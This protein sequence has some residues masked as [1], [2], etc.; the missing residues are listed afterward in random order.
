MNKVEELSDKEN[1]LLEKVVEKE[2]I[3]FEEL[4]N[5]EVGMI[6]RLKSR[7][8]VQVLKKKIALSPSGFRSGGKVLAL[9]SVERGDDY[10]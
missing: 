7:G 5:S 6:G 3:P 1:K 9:P 8:L 10:F 4:N 2:T